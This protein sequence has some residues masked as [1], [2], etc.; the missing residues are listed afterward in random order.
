V[1]VKFPAGTLHQDDEIDTTL[2]GDDLKQAVD[3]MWT[4]KWKDILFDTIN[5]AEKTLTNPKA[6]A[7]QQLGLFA[8]VFVAGGCANLPFFAEE[9]WRCIKQYL[10]DVDDI[11]IGNDPGNA[12]AEGIAYEVKE[13]SRRSPELKSQTLGPCMFRDLYV[14]FRQ[15]RTEPWA[16]PKDLKAGDRANGIGHLVASP[17]EGG[18]GPLEFDITL[19]FSPCR[20][21]FYVFF[22]ESPESRERT[23]LNPAD[24]AISLPD[25]G[26][27]FANIK[28]SL[29]LHDTGDIEPIFSVKN[30][31]LSHRKE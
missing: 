19:P 23:P 29:T 18:P 2:N 30:R 6:N 22:I 7:K 28:L 13:Q 25:G 12:V 3:A 16:A 20:R 15:A 31:V 11:K 9:L 26:K 27:T 4:S 14:A 5:S 17:L 21:L 8:R 1:H 24:D 10:R